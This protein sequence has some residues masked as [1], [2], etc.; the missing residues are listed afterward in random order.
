MLAH[1]GERDSVIPIAAVKQ[2]AAAHPEAEI[3]VY[4]ADHGFNCDQRGSYDPSSARLARER[5]LQFL[6]KHIG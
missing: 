2:F 5:S 3:H 6:R 1:F 4:P